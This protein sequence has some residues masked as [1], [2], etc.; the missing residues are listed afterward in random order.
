MPDLWMDV[1]VKRE[2]GDAYY[3]CP[4]PASSDSWRCQIHV[5]ANVVDTEVRVLPSS[6]VVAT[7]VPATVLCSGCGKQMSRIQP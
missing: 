4:S 6:E 2:P 5:P 3:V 7:I 1:T